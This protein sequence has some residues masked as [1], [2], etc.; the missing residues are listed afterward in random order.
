MGK[1]GPIT[2]NALDKDFSFDAEGGVHLDKNLGEQI[3][4]VDFPN[5]QDLRPQGQNYLVA[6]PGAGEEQEASTTR[7]LQGKSR[8]ATLT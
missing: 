7:I 6:G 8:K 4:V 2:L 1:N 3:L 5:P